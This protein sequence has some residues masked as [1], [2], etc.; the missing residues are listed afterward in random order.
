MA[1]LTYTYVQDQ[2][3]QDLFLLQ[4]GNFNKIFNLPVGYMQWRASNH[5]LTQ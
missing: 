4:N 2:L 3:E 1:F 5:S